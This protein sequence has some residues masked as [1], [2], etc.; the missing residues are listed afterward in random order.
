MKRPSTHEGTERHRQ[1]IKQYKEL[2]VNRTMDGTNLPDGRPGSS[3]AQLDLSKFNPNLTPKK[4]SILGGDKL[5]KDLGDKS[6]KALYD[7]RTAN[8]TKKQKKKLD[9]SLAADKK[10]REDAKKNVGTGK[11]TKYDKPGT[12]VSRAAEKVGETLNPWSIKNR[13][14]RQ[15][16]RAAKKADPEGTAARKKARS[17]KIADSIEYLFM[18]GQRP[19]ER[20]AGRDAA[21][22]KAAMKAQKLKN[23]KKKQDKI[24][25]NGN[26][27]NDDISG[28]KN[29]T[30]SETKKIYD[31]KKDHKPTW[32]EASSKSGGE[33]NNWVSQR[34]KH[35]KGSKEYNEIQNKIN[36]ALND[37]TRHSAE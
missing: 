29:I 28:S 27:N 12:V 1:E 32:E 21:A 13:A 33:L 35:K 7:I 8:M 30:T 34:D 6:Q 36:E 14:K 19:D 22:A 24:V 4:T 20:Q 3:P 9:K 37:P 16:K 25:D 15:E 2:Q 11:K 5:A 26:D 17:T 18:D 31:Y 10:F 23:K